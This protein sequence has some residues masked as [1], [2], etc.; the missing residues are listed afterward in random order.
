MLKSFTFF[1]ASVTAFC[2][3]LFT[4]SPDLFTDDDALV[5]FTNLSSGASSFI[6]DFGDGNSST[7]INPSNLYENTEEGA[8]ITLTAISDFGCID[9]TQLIIEYDE[10]EVFYI[11]NTFTPDGDN[12]NQMFT[13]VFYSGFDPYNFEM[14]IFNR[15]GE[16]VFETHNSEIGWDGTY[17]VKGTKATDGTY[18][19]KITYKNPKT[20]ERKVIVG[21]VTLMREYRIRKENLIERFRFLFIKN[22][23]GFMGIS[24]ALTYNYSSYQR[25]TGHF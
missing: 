7:Y 23:P 8:L 5:S 22:Q 11:P 18:S 12:F 1:S 20:D 15:W 19:W 10:Q 25:V 24:Y 16:I 2:A 21:H 9:Q 14:L 4:A 3:A 6:W 13:P 17:G